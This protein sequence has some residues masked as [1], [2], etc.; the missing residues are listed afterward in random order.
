MGYFQHIINWG[1]MAA[2]VVYPWLEPSHFRPR[3]AARI[4]EGLFANNK[5]PSL[6]AL[7]P[8]FTE[9]IYSSVVPET[10]HALVDASQNKFF[11]ENFTTQTKNQRSTGLNSLKKAIGEIL[12]KYGMLAGT[13][14]EQW[15]LLLAHP[16]TI[17][18]PNSR[19]PAYPALFFEKREKKAG[20]L[21]RVKALAIA[22][23]LILFGPDSIAGDALT[24]NRMSTVGLSWGI[25]SVDARMIAATCTMCLFLVYWNSKGAKRFEEFQPTGA[26]SQITWS[27][28]FSRCL[29]AIENQG[30][31][32]KQIIQ[33]W[34]RIV[35]AGYDLEMAPSDNAQAGQEEP[36]DELAELAN[37]LDG[38]GIE[39][40]ESMQ[41][42][43]QEKEQEPE[44]EPEQEPEPVQQR[45]LPDDACLQCGNQIGAKFWE[46]LSDEHSIGGDGV[47]SGTNDL[48]LERISVYYNEVGGNK[49]VR[50]AVL[51]DLE[52]G[53]M[54]S[55]RSGPLGGLF[56]PDN[57]VFG[58]NGAGNNW[59]KG[60][61]TEG[62]ELVNSVLDV[63][64][65]EAEGT[66]CL[67]GFQITHSLGGGTGSGMGTLLISKVREEYPDRMMCTY[68]VV[69]SPKVSDTVVEPYNATLSVHQLAENSD[70]TFCIDNE[71]LYDICFRTLKLSTPTYGDLNHL[72]SSVMSGITT[73]LRPRPA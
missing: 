4:P 18:D 64:R 62:A 55:V 31:Q 49:Y 1:K 10:F 3:N 42:P 11:A 33:F 71:A 2:L 5:P 45:E 67:Q 65:K 24:R 38:L 9:L 17:F 44:P 15:T 13:T 73:C 57:F 52:P 59:A 68:S 29:W 41:E 26:T 16:G 66:D 34:N 8:Y 36:D 20:H 23:R 48:Q 60:H 72:V 51:I 61:Y 58:Q 40:D 56:R 39:W 46:V 50:R 27:Q 37:A 32:G 6:E 21:F 70:E 47:Y 35:F 69:P 63:V 43:E 19:L 25:K 30:L 28:V 22:L 12:N 54:D 53:T 14:Q 7:A